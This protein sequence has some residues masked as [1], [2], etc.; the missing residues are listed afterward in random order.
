[1][2]KEYVVCIDSD[3]CAIDSMTVKHIKGFGQ[4]FVEVFVPEE[5]ADEG[6]EKWKEITV[7]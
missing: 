6:L 4:A 3:G 5:R 2:A 7:D 1:M